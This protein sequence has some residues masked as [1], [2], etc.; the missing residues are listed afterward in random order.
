V[1]QEL[2]S[3]VHAR[4]QK[5]NVAANF[6]FIQPMLVPVMRD[7]E[8]ADVKIEYPEDFLGQML[9][10]GERYGSLPVRN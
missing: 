6:A 9:E 2:R 1:D 8:I 7:G 4:Y 10:F 3:E 5:L